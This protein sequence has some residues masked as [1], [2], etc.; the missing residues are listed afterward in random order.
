[1][2][3]TNLR[4]LNTSNCTISTFIYWRANR[5]WDYG[6]S[7]DGFSD[8]VQAVNHERLG[9]IAIRNRMLCGQRDI[10]CTEYILSIGGEQ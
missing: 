8:G 5:I 4:Q 6:G 2:R 3:H 1:M 10:T 9:K 7:Y